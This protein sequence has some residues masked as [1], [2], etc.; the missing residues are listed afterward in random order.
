MQGFGFYSCSSGQKYIGQFNNDKKD[1]FGIVYWENGRV[2]IGYWKDG[3]QH[4]LG[5]YISFKES[6]NNQNS[7]GKSKRKMGL[8]EEGKRT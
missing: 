5:T 1:G 6:T 4:G 2:F 3:K 7:D 8:W